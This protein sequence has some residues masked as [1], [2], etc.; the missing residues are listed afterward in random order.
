MRVRIKEKQ[1]KEE[2]ALK[3]EEMRNFPIHLYIKGGEKRGK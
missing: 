1:G 2:M 3:K